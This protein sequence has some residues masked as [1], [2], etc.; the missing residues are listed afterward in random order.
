MNS[1]PNLS[2]ECIRLLVVTHQNPE[3]WRFILT[4]S[5]SSLSSS[6]LHFSLTLSQTTPLPD[7]LNL[8]LPPSEPSRSAQL[9]KLITSHSRLLSHL[10][11][12]PPPSPLSL[13]LGTLVGVVTFGLRIGVEGVVTTATDSTLLLSLLPIVHSS[14]LT[15]LTSLVTSAHSHLFP[16]STAIDT[17][18]LR[19]TVNEGGVAWRRCMTCAV[20]A[21]VR[22][23]GEGGKGGVF[24]CPTVR[25][26]LKCCH[27]GDEGKTQVVS[28]SV[29]PRFMFKQ[30]VHE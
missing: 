20:C 15:L 2:H 24:L 17:A 8:D 6:L 12:S 19:Q 16:F 5:L 29:S 18:L 11:L 28:Y 30:G 23:R 14:L 7:D 13:P 4:S 1:D 22:V 10:L 25:W 21:W 26:L 27:S 9:L 3:H